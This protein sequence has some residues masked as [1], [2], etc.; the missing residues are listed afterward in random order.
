VTY[1]VNAKGQVCQAVYPNGTV[2]NYTYDNNGNRLSASSVPDTT[3]PSAPASVTSSSLTSNSAAIGWQPATDTIAITGYRYSINGGTYTSFASY[4]NGLTLDLS[5]LTPG[6]TYT[7][8]V[9]AQDLANNIGAPTT[10]TFTLPPS[11]P[12]TPTASSVTGNSATISWTAASSSAGIT[13]YSYQLDGGAWSAFSNVLSVPLTGLSYGTANTIAVRA[14]DGNGNISVSATGSFSTGPTT[15]GTPTVSTVTGTSATVSWSASTDSLSPVS[16]Y[17]YQVNGGTWT[18]FSNTT[19]FTLTGLSYGTT[20]TVG[21]RSQDSAGN[22]S[23]VATGTFTTLPSAPGIPTASSITGTSATVSW[24]AATDANGVSGYRYQLNGGSWSSWASGLS[25]SLTGLAYGTSYTIDV[26]AEDGAGNVGL[27]TAGTFSTL[28]STPGAPSFSNITSSSATVTWAAATDASGITGYSY[29]ING[30][31]WSSWSNT[32]TATLT[33]LAYGT[34]YTV[35]VRAEDQNGNIGSTSSASFTTAPSAPGTPIASSITGA[36]ATVSWAAA[37]DTNGVSGYRYQI[38]GGAW[39]SWSGSLSA[40]LTGL[41][42]GSSYTVGVEAD[43]AAG[44]VS[45][46]A[47]GTFSTLPSTPGVPSFSNVT[48]T[49]ATVAWAAASDASGITGYSYQLNGGGWSSWSNTTTA[50]LTGLAY[51]TTYTV[52]VRAEDQYGNIGAT[53]SASF[54]T[55]ASAPGTP[56]FSSIGPTSATVTWAAATSAVG[57]AA[58]RYSINGGST[59]TSTGTALSVTLTGLSLGTAYTVWVEAETSSGA[60]GA[61][62]TASFTTAAY[63]T[64]LFS[65]T[66][67]SQTIEGT[68]KPPVIED[69]NCG[70]NPPSLGSISPTTTT[71]GLTLS[72]FYQQEL[73]SAKTY[74]TVLE[75]TGFTSDPGSGWLSSIG[76]GTALSGASATYSYSGGQAGWLW[77]TSGACGS[78]TLTLVHK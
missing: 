22:L 18:A 23:A 37:T 36:S 24:T 21:V 57:V 28:P 19:S 6:S 46:I 56:T 51:G 48:G 43:D 13:G 38:N 32:T 11:A 65:M 75:V 70:Y 60:W 54:T 47:T 59:W 9:E 42:Y 5:S 69:I 4:P 66:A 12:G 35:G 14:Q 16:G 41:V 58:Y 2:V 26:E 53:S 52:G 15:P 49:S 55:A 30:G 78:G 29:Q 10:T 20:Y 64:D 62:S 44:N 45:P 50:S 34:T 63:Y 68:G 40:S 67:G 76:F 61:S 7:V 74:N 39:S 72:T 1:Q 71:N 27:S 17:S 8:S 25:V 3:P 31:S 77:T 33:G 73:Y